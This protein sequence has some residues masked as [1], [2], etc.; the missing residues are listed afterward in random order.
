MSCKF[1]NPLTT[2]RLTVG[3]CSKHSVFFKITRNTFCGTWYL[4]HS[5]VHKC[6]AEL[7]HIFHCA[8]A[9]R[10]YFYF[11]SKIWRHHRVPRHRFT[12]GCRN[13]GNSAINNGQIAYFYCACAKC[14][15][16]YF[17][18]KIWRHH[19]VPRPR[20]PIRRGNFAH[21]AHKADIAFFIFAWIFRTSGL[22]MG[23][24]RGK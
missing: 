14:P 21:T 10:P 6:M 22:K 7:S 13:F 16:F 9:M 3:T 19:R 18:S 12:L 11:L 8:R 4:P 23:I 24:F 1:V 17:L 2:T 5:W 20:F 15:Y